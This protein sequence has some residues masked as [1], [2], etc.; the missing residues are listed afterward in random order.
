V[1]PGPVWASPGQSNWPS[2]A[3]ARLNIQAVELR[4]GSDAGPLVDVV[5]GLVFAVGTA[6]AAQTPPIPPFQPFAIGKSADDPRLNWDGGSAAQWRDPTTPLLTPGGLNPS[7]TRATGDVSTLM[8]VA[9][10]APEVSGE[11]G[12]LLYTNRPWRTVP[13]LGPDA[14]PVLDR[15]FVNTNRW[16]G[17]VNPNAP[18]AQVLQ[19]VFLDL[20]IERYPGE[21]S[22]PTCS[23]TQALALANSVVAA[24]IF[25]NRSDLGRVTLPS[26]PTW[27]GDPWRMKALIRNAADLLG[28]RQ[29]LFTFLVAGQSVADGDKNG[30]IT[31]DEVIAEARAVAVWWRDPYGRT[32]TNA[33]PANPSFVRFFKWVDE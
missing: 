30:T 13:L 5:T 9:N 3:G 18:D 23:T 24:R 33:V 7:F 12:F 17:F 8:Y 15:F 1:Y 14:I 32:G 22:A 19:C 6:L 26:D 10:R 27:N 31:D 28:T 4:E 2:V 11:L 29:N 20:P 21:P 16:R 25:T